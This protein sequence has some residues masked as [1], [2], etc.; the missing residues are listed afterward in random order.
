MEGR[1]GGGRA[2]FGCRGRAWEQCMLGGGGQGPGRGGR[3]AASHIWLYSV[4]RSIMCV[5]VPLCWGWCVSAC[6]A[7]IHCSPSEDLS[8]SLLVCLPACL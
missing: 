2:D 7:A 4:C 1:K 5:H 3:E 8:V 6:V